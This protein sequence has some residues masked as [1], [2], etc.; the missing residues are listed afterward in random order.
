METWIKYDGGDLPEGKVRIRTNDGWES[1]TYSSAEAWAGW[2]CNI[3]HYM[4]E[5]THTTDKYVLVLEAILG[6]E[7]VAV[8]KKI[9]KA[10]E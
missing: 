5:V 8:I 7:V 10:V 1:K 6:E 3:T 2:D 9:V 4:P